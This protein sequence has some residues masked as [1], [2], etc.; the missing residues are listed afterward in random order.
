[1]IVTNKDSDSKKRNHKL[2]LNP[3]YSPQNIGRKLNS[4]IKNNKNNTYN[5]DKRF[6]K[7]FSAFLAN[8]VVSPV[9]NAPFMR[10]TKDV[11]E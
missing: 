5:D 1:M 8:S 9:I 6:Y 4:M 10:R 3:R 7:N 11:L 2:G